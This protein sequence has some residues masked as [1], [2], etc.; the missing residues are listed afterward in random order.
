MAPATSAVVSRIKEVDQASEGARLALLEAKV[1]AKV[2]YLCSHTLL[3]CMLEIDHR[4]ES[5]CV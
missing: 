3:A 2:L 5:A 4:T 1:A